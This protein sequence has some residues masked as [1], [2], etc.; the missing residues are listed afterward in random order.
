MKTSK[1][2]RRSAAASAAA[3]AA[4]TAPPPAGAAA[5]A[6]ASGMPQALRNPRPDRASRALLRW[7]S[8]ARRRPADGWSLHSQR[9]AWRLVALAMGRRPRVANVSEWT[10]AGP[11]GPLELRVFTPTRS[12][13]LR[14]AFLWCHGGGF[15]IGGL[16]TADSICRAVALAA[17]CVTIA[18]RYRLAPEH[19]LHASRED[20][21]AAL[22]WVAR[23]AAALGVD[24]ARLAIGGDSAGGNISAAVAQEALHRGGPALALQVLVYPATDLIEEFPSLFE[25]SEG[26]FLDTAAIA[27]VKRHLA[28]VLHGAE[29]PRLS[30]RRHPDLRGLPP[31]LIVTAGFDPIRDDGLD[32]AARLRAAGVPVELLHYAGQFHG[33]MNFDSLLGAGRDAQA[34]IGAGLAAAFK[35]QA[36]PDRTIEIGDAAAPRERAPLAQHSAD[37]L[38]MGLLAWIA[39]GRWCDTLSRLAAPRTSAASGWLLRPMLAP[40]KFVGRR[41]GA[42]LDRLAAIQTYAKERAAQRAIADTA[43]A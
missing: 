14:P 8:L 19:D 40:A 29:H 12:T 1:P 37:W 18:V 3:S 16:D 34:R 36:T 4:G 2:S 24:P 7:M 39:L 23:H 28:G 15:V 22:E 43:G 6:G 27:S 30:P 11:G 33:F 17:D 31:A 10:I 26:Y 21:M 9:Q 41:L 32:Y 13:S 42:R 5:G 35:G 20:C 25:N 38:S